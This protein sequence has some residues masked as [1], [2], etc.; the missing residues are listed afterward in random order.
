MR[1]KID[2]DEYE[3]A[4][5]EKLLY[6]FPPIAFRVIWND[7]VVGRYSKVPRQLD[8]AVYRENQSHPFLVAEAKRWGRPID[9]GLI[10]C[11]IGKLDDI[12]PDTQIGVFVSLMA[13]SEGAERRAAASEIELLVVSADEA[14][15]MN[16]RP[17]ARQVYPWDWAFHPDLAAGLQSL[18]QNDEPDKII[19]RLEGI[20]FEEWLGFVNYGLANHPSEATNFLRFV[21][22]N[23]HDDGWRFNAVHQLIVSNSLSQ[24]DAERILSQE[25][26]PEIIGLLRDYGFV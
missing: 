15:Q 14:L 9:V 13:F 10:D 6:E 3:K 22:L 12:G 25:N 24:L 19:E 1:H 4:L 7:S 11:F 26:V 18:H 20:P 5:S 2:P 21:A 23:H 8:A 16:W 17:I